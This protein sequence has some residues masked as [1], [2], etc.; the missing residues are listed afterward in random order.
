M[1][2]MA[3]MRLLDGYKM[4]VSVPSPFWTNHST[5]LAQVTFLI[6]G[7]K[8]IKITAKQFWVHLSRK[9]WCFEYFLST[10]NQLFALSDLYVLAIYSE[11]LQNLSYSQ[12]FTNFKRV[13]PG[14]MFNCNWIPIERCEGY[15]FKTTDLGHE[16]TTFLMCKQIP[17]INQWYGMLL[18][19]SNCQVYFLHSMPFLSHLQIYRDDNECR[20]FTSTWLKG[21]I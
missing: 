1:W 17:F 19:Y 5:T 2:Q 3:L 7:A 10:T 11:Y 16:M 12:D 21:N 13:V 18:M 20:Q 6:L 4:I 15:Q 9:H 8:I 14:Y